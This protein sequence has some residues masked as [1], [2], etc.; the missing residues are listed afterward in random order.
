RSDMPPELVAVLQRMMAKSPDDRF[1]TPAEVAAAIEPF[2]AGCDLAR[3]AA[4]AAATAEGAVA[5]DQLLAVTESH[6]SSGVVGTHASAN[7]PSP[8]LGRGAG[9]E[10]GLHRHWF[11]ARRLIA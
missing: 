7:L 4:E 2:A 10:G 3:V 11:G 9:G 5:S 8:V 6:V 1:A